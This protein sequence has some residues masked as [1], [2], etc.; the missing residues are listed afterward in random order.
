MPELRKKVYRRTVV[1]EF[2][3]CAKCP[4]EVT[5]LRKGLCRGCY[6]RKYRG[7]A[8]APGARCVCGESNPIVLVKTGNAARCYNCRAL[9][10]AAVA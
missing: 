7:T 1:V 8:I 6:L 9:E 3:K 5:E 2:Q 4:R 10:R